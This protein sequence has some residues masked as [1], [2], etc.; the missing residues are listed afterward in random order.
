MT[1]I[2]IKIFLVA[3]MCGIISSTVKNRP[4]KNN[5]WIGSY[6]FGHPRAEVIKLLSNKFAGYAM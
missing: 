3:V 2:L 5:R 6:S 4:I 1:K